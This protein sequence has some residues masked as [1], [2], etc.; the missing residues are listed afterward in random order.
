MKPSQAV[1]GYPSHVLVFG[2]G[3]TG[4]ST[5]V[6][7]L[8][9]H[10]FRLLWISMDN[11]HSILQKLTPAEQ[12]LIELVV[13]PDT[14]DYP[15]GVDAFRESFKYNDVH[16]CNMHGKHNCSVCAKDTA[17]IF[18]D[19]NLKKMD[20]NWIVVFDNL[21]QLSDSYQSL[22]CKGKPVDYKLQLDDWGA[23]LFHLKK[24]LGDIQQA[25]FNI[26]AIAHAV[27]E[28]NTA[29]ENKIMPMV[30]SSQ[31]A[32]K[33]TGY[34]DHAVYCK[35]MNRE[36]RYGSSTKFAI[37]VLTKSRTDVEIEA[38]KEASLAPFFLPPL[39]KGTP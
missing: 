16:I 4:K 13:I 12:D 36:H 32:P 9:K 17:A 18:T 19:Y 5:L 22:V 25:P 2:D 21:S 24:G 15:T 3:G 34:F 39:P 29:G 37:N 20:R 31:F 11:G 30:G 28:K 23:L 7:E 35:V 26:C 10:G 38:M 1:V 8:T 27:E 14:R 6:S 33:V